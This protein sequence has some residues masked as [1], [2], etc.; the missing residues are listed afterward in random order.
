MDIFQPAGFRYN[1]IFY[2]F[3]VDDLE[4]VKFSHE[5]VIIF[6]I[7]TKRRNIHIIEYHVNDNFSW[8][9]KK[10]KNPKSVIAFNL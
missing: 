4:G 9:N 7:I 5:W 10:N 2:T 6:R 8:Q 3:Q 1:E